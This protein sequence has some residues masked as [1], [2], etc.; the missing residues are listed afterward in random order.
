[1]DRWLE[2]LDNAE[3]DAVMKAIRNP[4]WR[5]VDLQAVLV[6]EGA[7]KVADT[8]FGDWRRKMARHAG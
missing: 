3:R 6:D 7:P 5:H 2:S 8:T 1:M 4:E